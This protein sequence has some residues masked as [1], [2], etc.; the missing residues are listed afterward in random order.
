[1]VHDAIVDGI[2]RHRGRLIAG[3]EPVLFVVVRNSF[4]A[5]ACA[6]DI[7]QDLAARNAAVPEARGAAVAIGVDVGEIDTSAQDLSGWTVDIAARLADMAA[8]EEVFV[9]QFARQQV[10]ERSR[11]KFEDR[12]STTITADAPP[13][14]VHR[15]LFDPRPHDFVPRIRGATF[16]RRLC[17]AVL[18]AAG[19]AAL[20]AISCIQ[21]TGAN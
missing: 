18:V 21:G 19:V 8:G 5:L 17:T 11:F 3:A 14:T 2:A 6:I 7:Q 10:A 4:V 20:Y 13:I 16:Q 15:L 1:M 12:G 9:S